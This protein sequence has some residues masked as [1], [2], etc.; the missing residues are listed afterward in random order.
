[1]RICATETSPLTDI[2]AIAWIELAAMTEASTRGEA[3]ASSTE[4]LLLMARVT[5]PK[6][7][8]GQ[9]MRTSSRHVCSTDCSVTAAGGDAVGPAAG[10]PQVTGYR[11]PRAGDRR[12]GI[13]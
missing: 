6:S 8:I 4:S 2:A 11:E 10:F 5:S 9:A 1:M 12:M 13:R 7:M 3:W